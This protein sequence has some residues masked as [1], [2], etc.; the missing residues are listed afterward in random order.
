MK[1][2]SP[3]IG[4]WYKD[5]QT[6]A[7]FEVID[8]DPTTLTIET[9]YLDGEISEYDLDAWRE[10]LLQTA[11]APED[12]R[13]TDL[14]RHPVTISVSDKAQHQGDGSNVLGDPRVALAWLVNELSGLGITL[15]AGQVVTT[16]TCA[17]PIPV[18]PG[19]TVTADFGALGKVN[20]RF[21]DS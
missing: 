12:W 11:E 6:S 7:L 17:A 4:G 10:M 18:G 3:V 1:M 8:W 19:D 9:Q 16:G 14:V 13:S 20:L 5:L 21:S 15:A 2:L